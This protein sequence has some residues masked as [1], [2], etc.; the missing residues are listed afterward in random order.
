MT[1][2]V[3]LVRQ[4]VREDWCAE[5]VQELLADVANGAG[6]EAVDVPIDLSHHVGPMLCMYKPC[7]GKPLTVNIY[8][9][10]MLAITPVSAS[11]VRVVFV[12]IRAEVMSQFVDKS[13]SRV[14]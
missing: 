5:L 12:V 13:V 8:Y 2:V 7:I 1:G 9:V 3:P 10:G 4:A 11:L 6:G 14:V